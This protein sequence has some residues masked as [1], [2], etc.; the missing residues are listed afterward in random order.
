MRHSIDTVY[1]QPL[2]QKPYRVSSSEM[3]AIQRKV[4]KVLCRV[5]FQHSS[6]PWFSSVVLVTKKNG[7]VCSCVDH[8]CLNN[9]TGKDMYPMP[10]IDDTDSLGAARY[11]SSFDLRTGYWEN[12]YGRRGQRQ[13][14]LC[15]ARWSF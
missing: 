1:S 6:S 7:S 10:R 4:D 15:Y 9:V 8:R 14:S 12:L 2:H 11:F 3:G 5:I 13:N